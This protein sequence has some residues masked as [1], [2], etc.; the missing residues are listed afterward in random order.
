[1]PEGTTK[2]QAYTKVFEDLHKVF[3]D[4]ETKCD[5]MTVDTFNKLSEMI[6][7]KYQI[8]PNNTQ[9]NFVK[10]QQSANIAYYSLINSL[11]NT[12]MSSDGSEIINGMSGIKDFG[13]IAANRALS[14]V[15]QEKL[16]WFKMGLKDL[17]NYLF[18]KNNRPYN[19]EE[20]LTYQMK[21]W[22]TGQQ[23]LQNSQGEIAM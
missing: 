4:A 23:K 6:L 19:S 8:L 14:N 15:K 3:F 1:M 9:L 21:Q 12:K 20:L 7:R 10:A 11:F 13:F 18:N 17:W 5:E 22:L 16:N 2:E